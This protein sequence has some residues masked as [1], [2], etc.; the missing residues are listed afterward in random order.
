MLLRAGTL[1]ALFG[2]VAMML[3]P[4]GLLPRKAGPCGQNLCLCAPILVQQPASDC[5]CEK[6]Q[7]QRPEARWVWVTDASL[8]APISATVYSVVFNSL[9]LPESVA[10]VSL[11][12]A[13]PSDSNYPECQSYSTCSLEIQTPPPKRILCA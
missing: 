5:A 9:E 7:S 1:L 11:S 8:H 6:T 3:L 2:A 10:L 4:A 13:M 12:A